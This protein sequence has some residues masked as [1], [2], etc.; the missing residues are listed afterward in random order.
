[1][2]TEIPAGVESGWHMHPGEEVGY[3]LAGTVEMRSRAAQPDPPRRR[4]VPDAAPQRP[5]NALR[6]RPRDGPD[7]LDLHRRGG[8]VA[9][10][11]HAMT[12]RQRRSSMGRN[13]WA[14]KCRSAR[15]LSVDVVLAARTESGV[16]VASASLVSIWQTACS[17][18]IDRSTVEEVACRD[19]RRAASP[20]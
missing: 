13:P 2:L 8:R 19:Q 17:D 15:S 7:A 9:G 14:A 1:M 4:P 10:D 3:I 12:P 18:S 11:V 16:L 6:R 20:K 5:H